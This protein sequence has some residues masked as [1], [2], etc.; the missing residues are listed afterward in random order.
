MDL[1]NMTISEIMIFLDKMFCIF[2]D[3]M[4]VFDFE[5]IFLI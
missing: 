5:G 4:F 1:R 3:K 2:L